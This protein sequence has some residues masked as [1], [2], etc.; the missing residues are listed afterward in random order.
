[1]QIE[2]SV[3]SVAQA[4]ACANSGGDMLEVGGRSGLFWHFRLFTHPCMFQL[5][6]LQVS[7]PKSPVCPFKPIHSAAPFLVVTSLSR[8]M[9]L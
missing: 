9:L 3:S 1:M 8:R 6:T 2:F 7:R 5:A 4:V